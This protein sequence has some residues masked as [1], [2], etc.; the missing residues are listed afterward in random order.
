MQKGAQSSHLVPAPKEGKRTHYTQPVAR[1][2][3]PAGARSAPRHSSSHTAF[4]GF[5]TASQPSGSKLPRHKGPTP[6]R[7]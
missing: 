7:T 5:T 6:F 1:E 2:L 3:A 4:A